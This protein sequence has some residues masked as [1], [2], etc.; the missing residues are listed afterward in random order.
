MNSFAAWLK[1]FLAVCG[2]GALLS[3]ALPQ[4]HVPRVVAWLGA[5]AAVAL[6]GLGAGAL[7]AW[8]PTTTVVWN[9]PP[10]GAFILRWDAL[11]GVFLLVTGLVFLPVSIFAANSLPGL[12]GR[13]SMRGYGVLYFALL[14]SVVWTLVSGDV[15][16]FMVAWEI[17]SI[18]CY[19]LVNFEH[20]EED[21]RKASYLMLTISEAGALA[22]ALGLLL[23]AA[24]AGSLDFSQLKASAGTLGGGMRL[25]IFLLTFFGFGVKAGLVPVNVWLPRA[26]TAAPAAFVPVLAGATLNLGL[27]GILRVNADLMPAA[28]VVPGVIALIVGT[29]SALVGILYATT[30]GDLKTLLAHSSIENAGIITAG[31]G[32]GFIFAATGKPALS[33]FA[34]LVALYHLAN[35][36]LYKTLL[37]VGAGVVEDRAGTRDLDRLGG[38]I[39]LMPWTALAVLAGVLSISALPPFNGFVSEWLTLQT[40]LRSAELGS[41]GVKIVFALCGAGL[42]LTAALAVTCFVKLFAMGFLGMTRSSKAEQ[43]KETSLSALGPMAILAV[44]CLALGVLP[45]Y[46]I[47]ALD[48]AVRPIA[49]SSAADVLVPPFFAGSPGHQD[50]PPAF[51]G[52][53]HDLGAQVGQG[54]A[55]GRGLV[56]LHRGG[57]ANPVVFAG[58]PTYLIVVLA[59][60]LVLVFLVVRGTVSRRRTVTRRVCWDGGIR[61]LLPEMTYTATGFSNPVRVIF[62][63]IFRPT[64]ME[65]T[66][67]TVGEHFRTAIRRQSETVHVVDRVVLE[68]ARNI[69]MA[70]GS[71]LARMHHGRL[72]AYLAYA[73]ASLL[74]AFFVF[75][76]F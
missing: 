47:E 2:A 60:L 11:A 3:L 12:L 37:F 14:V 1:V 61:R 5:L 63:A 25:A 71:V 17:M 26:Y 51:A 69:A 64:I 65:D 31:F 54:V 46:V 4:R 10:I 27:Y 41:G 8:P 13:Y 67:E 7:L 29:A 57:T 43:A 22:A 19:L 66:R 20:E 56:I 45:T 53:F 72:N 62:D 30:D 76:F 50:L 55:P 40:L 18:L 68:P 44:L 9:V 52:E 16:S 70:V 74:V 28:S 75:T 15:F 36:S 38:L 35:H 48:H 59:G 34:F 32:A 42:A 39:R 21:N 33:A 49:G 58:A 6:I 73:L 23:L 24:N